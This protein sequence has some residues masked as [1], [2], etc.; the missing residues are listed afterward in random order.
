M[1]T[2]S[3]YYALALQASLDA[4]ASAISAEE[5][6]QGAYTVAAPTE[7]SEKY[8]GSFPTDPV[9]SIEGSLYWNS[10]SNIFKVWNGTI[11]ETVIVSSFDGDVT[12]GTANTPQDRIHVRSDIA[13]NWTSFNPILQLNEIGLE[14]DTKYFKFGNGSSTW[15]SLV[16]PGLPKSRITGIENVDNTSDINKPVSTLQATADALVLTTANTY[17]DN[18]LVDYSRDRGTY[19]P[20]VDSFPE[21]F[22]ILKGD[23]YLYIGT[24]LQGTLTVQAGDQLRALVDNPGQVA[25]DWLITPSKTNSILPYVVAVF[26]PGRPLA[27]SIGL[28]HVFTHQVIFPVNLV[29]SYAKAKTDNT[30]AKS[31]NIYY[32]YILVGSV[33]FATNSLNGTFTFTNE[34]IAQAGDVLQILAPEVADATLENITISLYGTR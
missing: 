34:L 25:S 30:L 21:T 1:P 5:S 16:Y 2:A 22:D 24:G 17:T 13:A 8:L 14:S 20:S 18:K 27:S 6:A 33:D 10:T 15:S 7:F 28:L 4:E 26:I 32:N 29:G 12:G 3:E 31:F 9:S 19:D 11:W 23:W